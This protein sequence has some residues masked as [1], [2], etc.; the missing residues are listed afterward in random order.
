MNFARPTAGA[1][2]CDPQ[3]DYHGAGFS[4]TISRTRHLHQFPARIFWRLTT[5]PPLPGERA[6]VRGMR[7]NSRQICEISA[8]QPKLKT[9]KIE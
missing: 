8:R 6:G 9:I 2:V 7:R 4:E 5:I 3:H 1:R